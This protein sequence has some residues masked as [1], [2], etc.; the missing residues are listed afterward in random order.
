MVGLVGRRHAGASLPFYA[1]VSVFD[2][3]D[4]PRDGRGAN[5][6]GILVESGRRTIVDLSL[7]YYRRSR[8]NRLLFAPR[9]P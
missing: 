1:S 8:E 3:P 4:A 5:G 9:I 2:A 6:T 7:L